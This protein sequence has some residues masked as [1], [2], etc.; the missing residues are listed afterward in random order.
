MNRILLLLCIVAATALAPS[1]AAQ[2]A[3]R[4]GE[5][6]SGTLGGSAS[7][8]SGDTFH[9]TW[10]FPGEAGQSYY[11]AASSDDFAPALRVGSSAGEPC[12]DCVYS[13]DD[14]R[15][16]Y[17]FVVFQV[18]RSGEYTIR[19]SSRGRA[20]TGGYRLSMN[21]GILRDPVDTAGAVALRPGEPAA[22]E[23]REGDGDWRG[24]YADV[25]TFRG[26][27]GDTVSI[28]MRA[29]GFAP[30]LLV[31]FAET[32]AY[33]GAEDYEYDEALVVELPYDG[34]YAVTA[35]SQRQGR[36]GTYTVAV[37]HGP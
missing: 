2:L 37:R 4:P 3:T 13:E 10:T 8:R 28:R 34:V 20:E 21:R 19:V 6:T 30:F 17:A 23:L 15:D 12:G 35:T 27:A 26:L 14:G 1:A 36:T 31:E 11:I 29:D 9:D 7:T 22:G 5:R 24:S 33:V 32:G 18:R 16:T 25:Y